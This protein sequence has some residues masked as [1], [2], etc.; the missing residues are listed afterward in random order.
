MAEKIVPK[1]V[2][3]GIRFYNVSDLAKVL[4]ITEYSARVYLRDGKIPAVKVGRKWFIR[5][6][7]LNDFLL[8]KGI[9]SMPDDEMIKMIDKAVGLKFSEWTE[10]AIPLMQKIVTEF[11]IEKEKEKFKVNIKKVEEKNKELEKVL[12][13]KIVKKLRYRETKLKKEFEKVK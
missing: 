3:K 5:E 11:L 6:K 9:R 8:C 1:K 4:A 12:P 10:K 13:E 2:M 7:S